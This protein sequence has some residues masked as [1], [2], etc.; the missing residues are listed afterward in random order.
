MQQQF[1]R[2][3][4]GAAVVRLA[5]FMAASGDHDAGAVH[6]TLGGG[7]LIRA[8]GGRLEGAS[9]R[10]GLA[11]VAFARLALDAGRRVSREALADAIWDDRRPASWESSLRNAIVAIRRWIATAGLEPRS[12]S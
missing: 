4:R 1:G 5:E 7:L 8:P 6:V 12:S 9:L 3:Q 2:K 11:E 10:S